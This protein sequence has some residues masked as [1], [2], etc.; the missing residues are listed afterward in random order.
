M[1]IDAKRSFMTQIEHR[2]S[3][4]I[5]VSGMEQLMQTIAD[6]LENYSMTEIRTEDGQSDDLLQCYLDALK[7]EGR[8]AKTIDQYRYEITR[9]MKD[10][11]T[12]TRSITVYHLR[13][14]ISRMKDGG[15]KDTTME[16]RRQ[17]ICAYFNWLQ[18]ESLITV[19]PTANLGAIKCAKK[20]KTTLDDAEM[21]RLYQHC[22]SKRDKLIIHF[23]ASTGCRISE[24][25]SLNRDHVNLSARSCIVH[26]K[27]NKERTVYF[28]RVTEMLMKEYLLSRGD[29]NEA[30]FIGRTGKR[31]CP[32][33][34]RKVLRLLQKE[35]GITQSVH[36]HK[37]RRTLATNMN[38][39]GMPIQTIA[40]ILGHEKL[41]TTMKY[42]MISNEE[43][44]NEYTR[45]A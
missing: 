27:G 42:V 19:N 22:K 13:A 29:D 4:T 21:E 5:T 18:R 8:S 35:A 24:A 7:V 26:G 17:V 25:M 10:V 2:M 14:W 34:V 43:T 9:M 38:R 44:R 23:L 31:L 30:L 36:P 39:R 12:P 3:D 40:N 20:T 15:L 16:S 11:K 41:D 1:A 28:D 6:V 33:G 45:Y 32:N 37:F